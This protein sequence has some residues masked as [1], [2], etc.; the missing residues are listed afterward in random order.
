MTKTVSCDIAIIG[1]GP[2]G[3]AA[4]VQA[5]EDGASRIILIERE[6]YLG[7]MLKQCIHDGF[8]ME[9]YGVSLTGP[10]YAQRKIQQVQQEHIECW[11]DATV[12]E[13]QSKSGGD[14]YVCT[15]VSPV[16]GL[17][18]LSA[19]VIILASG[20]RERTR[21]Q[22]RIPGSRPAGVYTAGTV[23]YMM[24]VQNLRPG[25]SAVILGSG[26]IGL[27]MARRMQ[28]EGIPVKMILGEKASGLLRN[29]IQCVKD[30]NIPLRFG[31][32]I[33][34]I[35]GHKR[36]TGVTVAPL[37]ADGVPDL[38]RTEYVR[39]DLLVVAAGL[40]PEL[41]VWNTLFRWEQHTPEPVDSP[42]ET[43]NQRP[44]IFVC[45]N[46]VRQYDTVDEVVRSGRR[47]GRASVQYLHL[48]HSPG[49]PLANGGRRTAVS[50]DPECTGLFPPPPVTKHVLTEEDLSYL[51]SEKNQEGLPE[52]L[53]CIRCP[54]GCRMTVVQKNEQEPEIRGAKCR[55]GVDYALSEISHPECIVTTTVS[56]SGCRDLLIPVRTSAPVPKSCVG[57]VLSY[58]SKMKVS[59]PVRC[60]DILQENLLD[61]IRNTECNETSDE[62]MEAAASASINVIACADVSAL[63]GGD[64]E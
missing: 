62:W 34:G 60:G 39:C 18:M 54:K 37:S 64:T 45:G 47:A 48:R 5:K 38:S 51:T 16:L 29:Y 3:M 17:T 15:V 25:R 11:N 63:I 14:G 53:C 49:G 28:W 32:T 50:G 21:G 52:I 30:W 35:H 46:V 40:I 24:N 9:E 12:I 10:E 41:E 59:L 1:G 55:N 6:M 42:D 20:C 33:T 2:A 27:I 61:V 23:Q 22:L 43:V 36:I 7:G 31:S 26:D 13:L 56:V 57:T 8:G 58:C 4:A 44:G 19:A